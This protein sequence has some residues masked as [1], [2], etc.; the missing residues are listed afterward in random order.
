[1]KTKSCDQCFRTKRFYFLCPKCWCLPYLKKKSGPKYFEIAIDIY[2]YSL[3]FSKYIPVSSLVFWRPFCVYFDTC[4]YER[5]LC[6]GC[7]VCCQLLFLFVFPRAGSS[8]ILNCS[9]FLFY[10]VCACHHCWHC[11]FL[12]SISSCYSS[13]TQWQVN[14]KCVFMDSWIVVPREIYQARQGNTARTKLLNNW[15]KCGRCWLILLN[16]TIVMI[17]SHFHL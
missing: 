2:V 4:T 17:S 15:M 16:W 10:C 9:S 1:M 12:H 6:R 11:I 5:D 3:I 14:S 8:F 13:C 7:L